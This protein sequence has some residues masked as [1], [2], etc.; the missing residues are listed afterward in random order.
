MSAPRLPTGFRLREGGWD[1]LWAGA[2]AVREAVFVVEQGIAPH[3]EWDDADARATHV[4]IEDIDCAPCATGRLVALEP[5]RLAR[6]GRIAVLR[7]L[8]GRGLG[9][10]VLARLMSLAAAQGFAR[11]VLH[12]Q[13]HAVDFYARRGFAV[14]GEEFVE[15]GIAHRRM[16]KALA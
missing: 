1:A 4:L 13:S 10:A 3:L 9:D 14:A 6:L 12:A 7:P 11:A 8:R 5:G 2:G 15:D 16:E